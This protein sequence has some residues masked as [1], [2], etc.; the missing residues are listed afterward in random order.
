MVATPEAAPIFADAWNLYSSALQRLEAGDV[1][2]AAEKA[3]AAT[4]GSTIALI[5]SCTGEEA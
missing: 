5:L 4:L 1:R 2:D 3:W